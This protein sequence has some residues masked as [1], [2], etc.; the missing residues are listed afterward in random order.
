MAYNPRSTISLEKSIAYHLF[1]LDIHSS[2]VSNL[3]RL[4]QK[5]KWHPTIARLSVIKH[6]YSWYLDFWFE[7]YIASQDIDANWKIIATIDRYGEL[8]GKGG[9]DRTAKLVIFKT[10]KVISI[11]QKSWWK[12]WWIISFLVSLLEPKCLSGQ[13]ASRRENYC[14][15]RY[16]ASCLF[17]FLSAIWILFWA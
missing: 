17:S 13:F 14:I 10:G 3:I 12:Y 16:T 6:F 9:N 2:T 4:C 11:V 1:K 7:N 8:L 15:H 5:S